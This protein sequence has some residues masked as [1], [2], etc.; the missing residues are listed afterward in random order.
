MA[1]LSCAAVDFNGRTKAGNL[2][3]SSLKEVLSSNELGEIVRGFK[4][5]QLVHP[6]CKRCLGSSSLGFMAV[7]ACYVN[8]GS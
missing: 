7:E 5:F 2:N 8:H 6:Y 1:M 3:N 4:K